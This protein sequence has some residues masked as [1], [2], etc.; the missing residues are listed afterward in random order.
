M[1]KLPD[2]VGI[3]F[4]THSVKAVELRNAGTA[5]ELINLGS[6]L[7]PKGV[8]N[9]EEK[10][11][12]KKLADVLKKLYDDSKIKNRNVVMALPEFSVFTRFLEFPGVKKEELREAVFF[13]A[14]QY[15][16]MSV[17]DVH[18][19]FVTIGF[20]EEK[21]APRVLLV[22]AP[23]KV[24]AIYTEIANLADLDL[25]A[26]ETESVAMGRAMYKATNKRDLVMLDF[27]ANST[28]MS[29]M[30]E[31]YL[32]FSQSIAIGSDALTQAVVN[33]FNF[34]YSR[35]EEFKRNYGLTPNVLEG[36]IY[37][38]LSPIVESI[39][40]EVQRGIEF[41]KNKT[42]SASPT[43]YLLNGDGAL[44][45]GLSEFVSK[46]LGVTAQIANPWVGISVDNKFKDIV[47]K[48]GPSYSVAIGLALKN[49]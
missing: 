32:V 2:H 26:I 23:K 30:S 9:S 19:S 33:K 41:Y 47:A 11:D 4:G 38:A 42:T 46:S 14:K 36:K 45:P 6:Q 17:N 39:L 48:G 20:N 29:I 15:I 5:P 49:E 35:A 25:I 43:E 28:D 22:A 13:E 18:M 10:Q 16:P 34:E 1:A 44:L 7:T 12:Q 3:D 31:G 24:I 21:N 40:M 37:S 27:G 8:I